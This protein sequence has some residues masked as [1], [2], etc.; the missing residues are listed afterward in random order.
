MPL[1]QFL[2]ALQPLFIFTAGTLQI[3][4]TPFTSIYLEGSNEYVAI[5]HGSFPGKAFNPPCVIIAFIAQQIL[6]FSSSSASRSQ[7]RA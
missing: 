2:N 3:S 7:A 1:K 6:Y 5:G 4:S